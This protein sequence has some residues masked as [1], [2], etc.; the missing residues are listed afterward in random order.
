MAHSLA[1]P[2]GGLPGA[3]KLKKNTDFGDMIIKGL[4]DLRFILKQSLK[5][6]DD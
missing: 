5:S 6:V 4:R 1:H 3:A 2:G